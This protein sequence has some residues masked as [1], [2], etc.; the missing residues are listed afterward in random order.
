MRIHRKSPLDGVKRDGTIRVVL[1]SH[2]CEEERRE[3]GR[4]KK[5]DRK[6]GKKTKKK[7]ES[8]KGF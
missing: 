3:T 5:N 2:F 1:I 6:Y 8:L 4:L 7:K